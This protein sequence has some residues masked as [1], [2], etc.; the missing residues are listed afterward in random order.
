MMDR[1]VEEQLSPIVKLRG[2][3]YV[4]MPMIAERAVAQPVLSARASI[5]IAITG[6]AQGQIAR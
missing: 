2:N 1:A 6:C 3:N 5:R 4:E